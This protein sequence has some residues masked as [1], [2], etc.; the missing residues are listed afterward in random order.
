MWT[1][2][3][4]HLC[5]QLCPQIPVVADL[6]VGDNLHDHLYFDYQVG[7]RD[8]VGVTPDQL[9]SFWAWLQ[10]TFFKT[11]KVYMYIIY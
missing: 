9:T 4:Q 7:V 3:C 8:P 1:D 6:P 11:G 2:V 10:Y 5:V